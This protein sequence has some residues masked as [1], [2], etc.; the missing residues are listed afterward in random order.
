MNKKSELNNIA[1][2][3]IKIN[4]EYRFFNSN[5][6]F[7][8]NVIP[9]LKHNTIVERVKDR[10]KFS[11]GASFLIT[12]LRGVG[13]STLIKRAINDLKADNIIC[14][15]VFI[16]LSKKIEY[17]DLL[18]EIIRRLYESIIDN[19][20]ID[21]IDGTIANDIV[22]SY[23]RTSMSIKNSNTINGELEASVGQNSLLGN[24]LLKNKLTKQAAEEA[25][26]LTY[27][28]ND[29]EHDLVRI[30]DLLNNDKSLKIKTII[31]FDELDKLTISEYGIDYFEDV[32][33]K[34]KSIICCVNA[35]SIFVGGLDLYQKWNNDVAKI[36]SLYDSIFSWHQYIP[37]IWESTQ[38]LFDLFIDREYVYEKIED[39]FQYLCEDEYSSIIK[40]AFKA[41]LIYINFKSKGIPRK[42]YSEF[43][44]FIVWT[45]EKPYFQISETDANEISAYSEIWGKISPIFEDKLYNTVIEM[46]LTYITCF[47]IIEY[48][49]AHHY[50]IFSAEDIEKVLLYDNVLPLNITEI[51]SNLLEKFE[52]YHIIKRTQD[53]KYAVTDYTIKR[54]ESIAI[55]DKALLQEKITENKIELVKLSENLDCQESF[56][57]KISRYDSNEITSFWN[58]FVAKDLI[59]T[60]SE[61]SIFYV[62]NKT[63]NSGYNAVLYTDKQNQKLDNKNCLYNELKYTITSKYLLDT[64]DI[65]TNSKLKTSLRQIYNGYLL[66]HLVNASLE[67]RYVTLIIEQI[68]D[69][70]IELNKCGFFNANVKSNNIMIN[71]YLNVKFLDIKNLIRMGTKGTPISTLG[72]AAPEMYTDN[73]DSRSDLYSVGVLLWELVVHKNLSENLTERHIDFQFVK[74][75]SGCTKKLW[76]IIMK[77]T[78]PNPNERYQ[79]AE[80]FLNDI[81]KSKECK[82]NKLNVRTD[83]PSGTVTNLYT[84][85]SIKTTDSP[86][87]KDG[88]DIYDHTC[89]LKGEKF[90]TTMLSV[91]EVLKH[92]IAYLVRVSTNEMILIDRP[93][94]K[95]GK[96]K[97]YTD[98][99]ITD[100]KAISRVHAS[101]ITKDNNYYLRDNNATNH[102]YLNDILLESNEEKQIKDGDSIILANERFVFVNKTK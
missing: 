87:T 75:P 85:E 4:E 21:K 86:S 63:N 45:N 36:N 73:F 50:E 39:D 25:S 59:L 7:N 29:V 48:F 14:L 32:L 17:K 92:K 91:D 83:I 61:M 98:L 41:F 68:L 54:E 78:N 28:T 19:R 79:T 67:T 96:E 53:N 2:K 38:T 93:D 31:T 23:S 1:Y 77:A 76:Q 99:C 15:P 84:Y 22:I 49:F 74:K 101:I 60:N 82:R 88:I 55:K 11:N 69:F 27:S 42:I 65:I 64:T 52:H 33:S 16:N 24:I 34:L 66:S 47:N 10:I 8:D 57:R 72:Y 3:K 37:C 9:F 80:E 58:C 51:I 35:I 70:I 44:N 100:N 56:L 43:N 30:I 97:N 18:F 12:G 90:E 46:D 26:F 89:I 13:K 94:F 102:T 5:Y 40:P 6:T 62:V 71:K 20:I 95:I 81:R